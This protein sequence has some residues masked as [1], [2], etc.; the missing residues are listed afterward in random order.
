MP[1]KN[2]KPT[3][4]ELKKAQNLAQSHSLVVIPNIPPK[5]STPKTFYL[6]F[7]TAYDQFMQ[8]PINQHKI[9]KFSIMLLMAAKATAHEKINGER[10]RKKAS[11]L[12]R[13]A[14]NVLTPATC[15][16]SVRSENSVFI[17]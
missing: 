14:A 5:T 16:G 13:E 10:M 3:V 4:S 12:K 8:H 6:Y 11:Y 1:K 17:K 7:T 2:G 15:V 9:S